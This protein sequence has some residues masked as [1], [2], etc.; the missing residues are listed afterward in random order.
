VLNDPAADNAD[1][2]REQVKNAA[3]DTPSGKAYSLDFP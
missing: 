3:S 2:Y 1:E